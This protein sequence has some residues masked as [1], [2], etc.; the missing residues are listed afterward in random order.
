[1]KLRERLKEA[2]TLASRL[3][4]LDR[5]HDK[6]FRVIESRA[7]NQKL[8]VAAWLDAERERLL[9]AADPEVRKLVEAE[10]G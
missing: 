10:D 1:M 9:A 8:A 7:A 2:E 4:A 5:K 3:E 6:K